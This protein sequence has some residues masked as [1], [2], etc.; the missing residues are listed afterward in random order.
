MRPLSNVHLLAGFEAKQ[1]GTG[2]RKKTREKN[3]RIFP[4]LSQGYS[5]ER[6]ARLMRRLE[7]KGR[8][9]MRAGCPLTELEEQLNCFI[10]AG[11]GLIK[12][13]R[14]IQLRMA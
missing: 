4:F 3:G 12:R 1:S 13:N 11:G 6:T 10:G 9:R 14:I 2:A 8:K 7:L 5:G